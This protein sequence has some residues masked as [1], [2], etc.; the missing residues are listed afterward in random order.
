LNLVK[1]DFRLCVELSY[2]LNK[3]FFYY[4]EISTK[5]RARYVEKNVNVAKDGFL[6][7]SEMLKHFL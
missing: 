2:K 6:I 3:N 7:M 5:E 1:K 4:F